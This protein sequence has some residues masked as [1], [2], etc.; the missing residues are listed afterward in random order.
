VPCHVC[1]LTSIAS[2]DREAAEETQ[3]KLAADERRL[4]TTNW[5]LS[6]PRSSAFIGG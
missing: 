5:L 1:K 2:R 3:T 6:Y 4:K